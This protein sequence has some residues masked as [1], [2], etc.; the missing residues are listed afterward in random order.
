RV[1]AG[2]ED[3]GARHVGR[4]YSSPA[5]LAKRGRCGCGIGGRAAGDER[6][7]RA[8]LRPARR[9]APSGELRGLTDGERHGTGGRRTGAS[10]ADSHRIGGGGARRDAA[11]RRRA[12][13]RLHRDAAGVER[14]WTREVLEPGAERLRGARVWQ[15]GVE[16]TVKRDACQ[17]DAALDEIVLRD[18]GAE[19]AHP[20]PAQYVAAGVDREG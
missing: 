19:A 11:A 5:V 17:V 6:L 13:A 16:A 9:T 14:D 10:V 7:N 15:E 3:T 12:V 20:A 8:D 4:E 1:H 18:G 2:R